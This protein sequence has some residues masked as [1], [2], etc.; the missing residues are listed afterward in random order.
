MHK[1]R[2]Q[3]QGPYPIVAR[4]GDVDYVVDLGNRKKRWKTF[5][6]KMLKVWQES[7]P[8]SLSLYTE[9]SEEEIDNDVFGM[10]GAK[11]NSVINIELSEQQKQELQH[12]LTNYGDVFNS[13][14]GRMQLTKHYIKVET[15]NPIRQKLCWLT[16]VYCN[17]VKNKLM[18]ME[19]GP[20]N[21]L[22]VNGLCP[23]FWSQ[24]KTAAFSYV[25]IIATSTT[26]LRRMPTQC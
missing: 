6:M 2:A 10:K 23:L 7:K 20:S 12:I 13:T 3:W 26:S 18:E 15:T 24:R 16:H 21:H 1:F 5:H 9:I 4:Q 14:P 17:L 8:L 11:H 22:L 25:L 19:M